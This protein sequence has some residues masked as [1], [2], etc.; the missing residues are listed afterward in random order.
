[1][2]RRPVG[3]AWQSLQLD[4]VGDN[5]VVGKFCHHLPTS[6]QGLFHV[7]L[8]LVVNLSPLAPASSGP[9]AEFKRTSQGTEVNIRS[10]GHVMDSWTAAIVD[11]FSGTAQLKVGTW[12]ALHLS[13]GLHHLLSYVKA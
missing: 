3:L 12:R 8:L 13:S 6:S 9:I 4:I 2:N 5:L 10:G 11:S 1:M 7:H